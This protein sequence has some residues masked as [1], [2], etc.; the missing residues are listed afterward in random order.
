[1]EKNENTNKKNE[2]VI[3]I[4]KDPIYNEIQEI[5]TDQEMIKKKLLDQNELSYNL[6]LIFPGELILQKHNVI[7]LLIIPKNY[8]KTEPELYCLTVFSH[9]HLCDGRNLINDIFN[10]EWTYDNIPID[11]IINRIPKFIIKN[12]EYNN[13][14]LILG[15]Y[16][17]S[18]LYP[19]SL[20]KNLP[21][22]FHLIPEN[23][24]I[25]TIGDISLC[26]YELEK[27]N[28]FKNCKLISFINIKDIIEIQTK[29]KTNFILIKYKCDKTTK[30]LNINSQNVETI[31]NILKE[32]MKIYKKKKGKLP[33]IDIKYLE[34]EIAQKE[35]ELLN[36]ENGEKNI[37]MYKEK[38]LRLMDLYQQSIEY[39]SAVND[40]K[41]MDIN[42]KIRKLIESNKLTSNSDNEI[43]DNDKEQKIKE[44]KENIS[45]KNEENKIKNNNET[46]KIEEKKDINIIKKEEN[47]D[48]NKKEIINNKI[49]EKK[50]EKEKEKKKEETK[51]EKKEENKKVENKENKDKKDKVDN[52]SLRLKIDEGEI[53][54]LDVGEDE[55]EEEEEDD[56]DKNEKEKEK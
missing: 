49:N 9:P 42:I 56:D 6:E 24:N 17:M 53:N 54:T 32:K 10:K 50:E 15:K 47:K 27:E 38:C 52:N 37:V 22:F 26:L 55:E 13:K 51:K 3:I 43:K 28:N 40:P 16:M 46:K 34:K 7:F 4:S 11:V 5:L 19:I 36:K 33:D 35:K 25:I 31:E 45:I 20:L 48:I 8:P 39:Y 44:E 21:I 30:K 41:F 23:N 14:S 12:S 18:H 2:N 29:Q 1:M